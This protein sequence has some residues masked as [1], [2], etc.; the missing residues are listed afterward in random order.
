[1]RA[2]RRR[3]AGE[4]SVK[5]WI[6]SGAL[7]LFV[8]TV[9]GTSACRANSPD[10]GASAQPEYVPTATVR[11][12]MLGL[13]DPAADVVWLSV[14]TVLSERGAVDTVPRTD[15]EWAKVRHGAITLMEAANLLMMPGRQVARHGQKS[16]APGIELEPE[17]M[18]ALIAKD[19]AAWNGRAK[20]LHDA[21][22]AVLQAIDAKDPDKVFE[23]GAEIEEACETCHQQYWYPKDRRPY[24]QPSPP[25]SGGRALP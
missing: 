5:H 11:D 19:R 22:T 1:M 17:E 7:L 24:D 21:G 14:T 3:V 20:K 2:A 15:E 10:P 25:R 8:A 6:L 18:E 13:V 12:L 4:N 9:I 16:E 23:L